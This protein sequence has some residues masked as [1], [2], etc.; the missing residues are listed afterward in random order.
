MKFSDVHFDFNREHHVSQGDKLRAVVSLVDSGLLDKSE[1]RKF[2][3]PGDVA[4]GVIGTYVQVRRHGEWMNGV[5]IARS[6]C[7]ITVQMD[8]PVGLLCVDLVN[9]ITGDLRLHCP[10]KVLYD[11]YKKTNL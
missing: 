10:S 4:T 2:V 5:V 8:S 6:G 3:D 11:E 9:E 7:I 1:I